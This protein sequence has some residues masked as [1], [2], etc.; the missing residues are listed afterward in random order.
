M[1]FEKKE[2]MFVMYFKMWLTKLSF[3]ISQVNKLVEAETWGVSAPSKRKNDLL[4]TSSW[5]FASF[6]LD[7]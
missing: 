5:F 7:V 3:E 2:S 4:D 1:Y 6:L